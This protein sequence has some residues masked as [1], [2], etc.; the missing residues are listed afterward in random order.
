MTIKTR[1]KYLS[2]ATDTFNIFAGSFISTRNNIAP[3]VPTAKKA[4]FKVLSTLVHENTNIP[5]RYIAAT[6]DDAIHQHKFSRTFAH[7]KAISRGIDS[8]KFEELMRRLSDLSGRST[9]L[10]S[11]I[12]EIYSLGA[13]VCNS[14]HIAIAFLMSVGHCHTVFTT[15][16]DTAIENACQLIGYSPRIVTPDHFPLTRDDDLKSA[17]VKLHGCANRGHVIA[18]STA[19]RRLQELEHFSTLTPLI[20]RMPCLFFGYS[21]SGDVDIA[22]HLRKSSSPDKLIWSNHRDV[23]NPFSG[24]QTAIMDLLSDNPDKNYLIALAIKFGWE[25]T[26]GLPGSNVDDRLTNFV[27]REGGAI[28][29]TDALLDLS[30]LYCPEMHALYW[31][32]NNRRNHLRDDL[33]F[34]KDPRMLAI[35]LNDECRREIAQ[36]AGVPLYQKVWSAFIEWRLGDSSMALAALR[37]VLEATDDNSELNRYALVRAAEIAL[38]IIAETLWLRSGPGTSLNVAES[39]CV[40]IVGD[41]S[42]RSWWGMVETI[43]RQVK[44]EKR[45]AEIVYCT[46]GDLT[47]AR[48]EMR[49]LLGLCSDLQLYGELIGVVHS[50]W[51]IDRDLGD[52]FDAT[53]REVT[54]PTDELAANWKKDISHRR[55]NYIGGRMLLWGTERLV[56]RFGELPF[57]AWQRFCGNRV[58][59]EF[60]DWRS[61]T[62]I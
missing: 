43:D 13:G 40:K 6:V 16:F 42:S 9:F 11:I 22:P 33:C 59:K 32:A 44:R 31:F 27:R 61:R 5:A 28:Y 60:N 51:L 34:T 58:V 2:A 37:N 25:V 38:G 20:E 41:L 4:V 1:N 47:D 55:Y 39:E 17:I 57:A 36:Y 48:Q 19:F 56:P 52:E 8:I 15:N 53:R 46:S 26:E 50:A 30:G 49:R 12:S 21:G 24:G 23:G 14:N 3:N 45:L 62:G 35:P 54:I 18:N 29:A 10:D 7:S